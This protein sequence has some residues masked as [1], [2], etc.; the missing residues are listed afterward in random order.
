M[1]VR[2]WMPSGVSQRVSA[3]PASVHTIITVR[4][5]YAWGDNQRGVT[6]PWRPEGA[7]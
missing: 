3:C 6:E 5:Q 7:T 1:A 4:L 2:L